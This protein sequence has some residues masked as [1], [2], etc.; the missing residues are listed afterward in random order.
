MPALPSYASVLCAGDDGEC[1]GGEEG[2]SDSMPLPL[3]LPLMLLL[4][5]LRLRADGS[6]GSG[7]RRRSRGGGKG[8]CQLPPVA[9]TRDARV[10]RE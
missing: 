6:S 3:P 4:L 7:V 1:A 8:A 5:L 10:L 9:R 2:E